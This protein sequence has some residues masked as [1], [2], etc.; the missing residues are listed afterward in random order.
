MMLA[1]GPGAT[2]TRHANVQ[3][4]G[5][6]S[7]VPLVVGVGCLKTVVED[8]PDSV[9]GVPGGAEVVGAP[10]TVVDGDSSVAGG[11]DD[12]ALEQPAPIATAN[13]RE[14]A[15]CKTRRDNTHNLAMLG[16]SRALPAPADLHTGARRGH[17]GATGARRV[18][19][20]GADV[21]A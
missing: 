8:V 20:R 21:S 7:C 14:T 13:A 18:L 5:V 17:D 19:T 16:G 2:S 3:E 11:F 12:D 15:H 9:V 6:V 10:S 1:Q 4:L